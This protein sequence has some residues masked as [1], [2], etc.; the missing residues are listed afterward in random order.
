MHFV[1]VSGAARTQ[2]KSN[3]AKI[4][5]AFCEGLHNGGNT[6]EIW[7]LSD[8]KQW[9]SAKTAF[10]ENENILFAL[11]LYVENVPGIML[12]FLAGLSAKEQPRTRVSF[13]LQ[14]GFPEVSQG[15]CCEE[16]LKTLPA[17]LGCGYGGTFIKGDMFGLSLMGE[18]MEAKLL[19]PFIEIGFQFGEN[20]A[21][22]SE[23]IEIFST[24]EYFLEKQIRMANGPFRYVQR[25]AMW[26]FAK[27][28]GCK[29]KLDVKPFCEKKL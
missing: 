16:F 4:I 2:S 12:G 23:I 24:P 20:G 21:F 8:R 18:K 6:S 13:L 15:R 14:G 25:F 17:Q 26:Y 10:E 22:R 1:I 11:P 7:Y 3:T 29:T 19:Q 5:V 9:K 27:R 28:L